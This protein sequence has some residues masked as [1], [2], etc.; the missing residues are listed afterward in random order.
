[1]T[2]YHS[3][4]HPSSPISS[5]LS[6]NGMKNAKPST[7]RP[8]AYSQVRVFSSSDRQRLTRFIDV[9]Q[10]GM[11]NKKQVLGSKKPI[12]GVGGGVAG[13]WVLRPTEYQN[14]EGEEVQAGDGLATLGRDDEIEADLRRSLGTD[15][16]PGER[17]GRSLDGM[18]GINAGVVETPREVVWQDTPRSLWAEIVCATGEDIRQGKF[19][20]AGPFFSP[21]A[22]D[23]DETIPQDRPYT[24]KMGTAQ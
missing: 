22:K 3:D 2:L 11:Q 13:P 5:P 16:Q 21:S 12:Q 6:K 10:L 17:L 14:V 24:V 9:R 19:P 1:M 7:G 8:P 4:G 23:P 20:F 18:S 15:S